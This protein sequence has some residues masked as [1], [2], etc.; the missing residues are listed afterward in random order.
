MA[1]VD[2]RYKGIMMIGW[3]RMLYVRNVIES[4]YRVGGLSSLIV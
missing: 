3:L 4:V 2:V 1:D